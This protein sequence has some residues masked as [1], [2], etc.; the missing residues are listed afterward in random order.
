MVRIVVIGV[1]TCVLTA[2]GGTFLHPTDATT[3]KSTATPPAAGSGRKLD[4]SKVATAISRRIR[5][6]RHV[7]ADV[8]CPALVN[9]R[10]GVNFVCQATSKFGV[11]LF[12]VEQ[13]GNGRVS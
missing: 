1:L 2:G 7:K 3:S 12:A 6:E 10:K 8:N 4:T 13:L 9:E 5:H 11:T